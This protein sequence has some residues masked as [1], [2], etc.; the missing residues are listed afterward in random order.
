[1]THGHSIL[2]ASQAG[3]AVHRVQDIPDVL[4]AVFGSDGLLLTEDDLSPAVFDLRSGIA[5]ELFQKLVNYRVRTALV[6]R[7]PQA[8]GARFA[9]LAYEHATH[10]TIRFFTDRARALAWLEGS[11]A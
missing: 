3:L 5:G 10:P 1:M 2:I 11:G 7:D 8:H 4:G 9:E 6:L